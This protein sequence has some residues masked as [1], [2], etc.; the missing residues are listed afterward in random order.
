MTSK[1]NFEGALLLPFR[2]V[3]GVRFI[4]MYALWYAVITTVLVVAALFL[5]SGTLE[6]V[7][8]RLA[9]L[10]S[11]SDDPVVVMGMV[12]GMLGPLWPFIILGAGLGWV[13]T[14]AFV[15]ASHRRFIRDEAF[16]VRFGQDELNIMV[17]LLLWYLLQW[18]FFAIPAFMVF[19]GL[20]DIVQQ[21][22]FLSEDELAVEFFGMF[23]GVFLI[24]LVLF[25]PYVFVAT[26]LAPCFSLTI[27]ERK[28]RFFDAW[29]VSRGRFWAILGAYLI[30]AIGGNF[31]ISI[32]GQIIELLLLPILVGSMGNVDSPAD[33]A[34]MLSSFSGLLGTGLYVFAD[35]F[36]A[37]VLMHI[38]AGP[39]A[40]ATRHDPRG[41]V[42]DAE[43]VSVFD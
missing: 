5:M 29:H 33:I 10:E 8:D 6:Q 41:G 12:W 15:A 13:M 4:A 38:V 23:G 17:V 32:L 36:L 18:A 14:A 1:F 3:G 24:A 22:E 26:R 27:K 20:A 11:A 42:E 40:F 9:D 7:F 19:S 34:R 28:I 25:I 21:A 43:K 37:G 30:L 31:V 2:A 16:S 35:T 39:A